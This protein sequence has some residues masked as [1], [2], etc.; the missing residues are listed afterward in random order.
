MTERAQEESHSSEQDSGRLR[1][2]SETSRSWQSNISQLVT[3]MW[4][5]TSSRNSSQSE[6]QDLEEYD[7]E[8][9]W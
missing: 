3:T 8:L 6:Q 5:G 9:A 4:S 7:C 2:N 1:T